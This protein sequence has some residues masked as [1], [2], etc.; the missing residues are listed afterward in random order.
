MID[1]AP[2]VAPP[3]TVAPISVIADGV[4]D[5]QTVLGPPAFTVGVAL[6]V[7]VLVVLIAEHAVSAFVVRV[8]V[9]VPLKFAAGV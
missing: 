9:T 3:P 4:P 5:W 6:T 7:I 1:H 2:V 8:K